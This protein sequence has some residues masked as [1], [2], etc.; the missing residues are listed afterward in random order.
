[1]KKFHPLSHYFKLCVF[2]IIKSQYSLYF[3]IKELQKEIDNQN[4]KYSNLT[5]TSNKILDSLKKKEQKENLDFQLND[6]NR[7]W[8]QLRK[9]SLEIRFVIDYF[10]QK[11]NSLLFIHSF[12]H[13]LIHLF[14]YLFI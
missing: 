8:S 3:I 4:I 10:L 1:M 7:R 9:K 6:I 5:D 14:I 2:F 13:S 11:K 12:I